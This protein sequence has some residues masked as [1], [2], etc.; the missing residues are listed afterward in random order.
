MWEEESRDLPYDAVES[1]DAEEVPLGGN[2]A[3]ELGL[4]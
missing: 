2:P 4:Y 1:G 3:P